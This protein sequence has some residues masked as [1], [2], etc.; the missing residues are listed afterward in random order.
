MAGNI[1][2][3]TG[4]F[5]LLFSSTP[6]WQMSPAQF[7]SINSKWN[8]SRGN[9]GLSVPNCYGYLWN[10]P[11][12]TLPKLHSC[13]NSIMHIMTFEFSE[14]YLSIYDLRCFEILTAFA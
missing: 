10:R 12:G 14:V 1:E 13:H 6:A 3:V 5:L 4:V 8:P 2:E 11:V 9:A 7:S